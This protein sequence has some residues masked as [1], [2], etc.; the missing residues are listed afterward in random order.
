MKYNIEVEIDLKR[1]KVIFENGV[2]VDIDKLYNEDVLGFKWEDIGNNFKIGE[3][4][5]IYIDVDEIREKKRKNE[6][7]FSEKKIIKKRDEVKKLT[8]KIYDEIYSEIVRITKDV[9][10]DEKK[11]GDFIFNILFAGLSFLNGDLSVVTDNNS[12]IKAEKELFK[13]YFLNDVEKYMNVKKLYV[14]KSKKNINVRN[15]DLS[16]FEKMKEMLRKK[17]IILNKFKNKKGV[18]SYNEMFN[19]LLYRFILDYYIVKKENLND[20]L[21]FDFFNNV[22]FFEYKENI[23]GKE[24]EKYVNLKN[25]NELSV[26]CLDYLDIESKIEDEYRKLYKFLEKNNKNNKYANLLKN[27]KK[28]FRF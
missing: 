15:I 13:R 28:R 16:S 23:L 26:D 18:V 21:Y 27:V 4:G 1:K 5:K 3:G 2:E 12:L 6:S 22:I 11:I 9:G 7:K 14:S 25:I 19:Y 10:V 17:E 8:F 24:L 20:K